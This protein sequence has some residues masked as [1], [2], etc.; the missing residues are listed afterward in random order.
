MG[1]STRDPL[2]ILSEDTETSDPLGILSQP[3]KKKDGTT[4]SPS[5]TVS[6]SQQSQSQS[7]VQTPQVPPPV[8]KAD[9][10][11]KVIDLA[12]QQENRK[13]QGF[14]F[15]HPNSFGTV[16]IGDQT[17]LH[18]VDPNKQS[19]NPN[20]PKNTVDRVRSGDVD[21]IVSVI[22][23]EKKEIATTKAKAAP[24]SSEDFNIGGTPPVMP[25]EN[26]DQN[27]NAGAYYD[28]IQ[29]EL[30]NDGTKLIRKNIGQKINDDLKAGKQP[31]DDVVQRYGEKQ[32]KALADI[33]VQDQAPGADVGGY[34]SDKMK[35]EDATD[36]KSGLAAQ[37]KWSYTQQFKYKNE[38]SALTSSAQ[39]LSDKL[40]RLSENP[41]VKKYLDLGDDKDLKNDP[42]VK[43]F[44]D[45]MADYL[46]RYNS[47]KALP[48]R[49]PAIRHEMEKQAVI[50][51]FA[52]DYVKSGNNVGE[53]LKNLFMPQNLDT[54][55]EVQAVKQ[56]LEKQGI[57]MSE[58]KIRQYAKD[59]KIPSVLGSVSRGAVSVLAGVDQWLIR[60]IKDRGDAEVLNKVIDDKYIYKTPDA[61]Q[62]TKNFT[63]NNVLHTA[64]DGFGQFLGYVA[65][66]EAAAGIGG[67]AGKAIAGSGKLLG[68]V[69][70][71]SEAVWE[72]P[73]LGRVLNV[74][75]EFLAPSEVSAAASPMARVAAA[76]NRARTL[77]ATYATGH[78]SSWE[79]A[80]Q[81]AK[82]Y[83]DDP[84]KWNEYAGVSAFLNGISEL[85]L[86][87]VDVAKK[88][89]ATTGVKQL[90]R[91]GKLLVGKGD[92]TK[93]WLSELGKIVGQET[94]EEYVPLI[95]QTIAKQEIF[96]Y[97]TSNADFMKQLWDTTVQTIISSTPMGVFGS[98]G[99]SASNYTKGTLYEVAQ[100][101]EKYN[102]VIDQLQ[103]EGKLNQ[104]Q[105][106]DR[107][108][109][110]NTLSSIHKSM[111]QADMKGNELSESDKVD[112]FAAMYAH[113]FYGAVV[114]QFPK[115]E[116]V[117]KEKMLEQQAII[118]SIMKGT[119][120]PVDTHYEQAK[121]SEGKNAESKSE[122]TKSENTQGEETFDDVLGFN[123]TPFADEQSANISENVPNLDQST[124]VNGSEEVTQEKAEGTLQPSGND[125]SDVSSQQQVAGSAEGVTQDDSGQGIRRDG[126]VQS[127]PIN[128]GITENQNGQIQSVPENKTGEQPDQQPSESEGQG[129]AVEETLT[130]LQKNLQAARQ[131]ADRPLTMNERLAIVRKEMES[132]RSE[133]KTLARKADKLTK[134]L[135]ATQSDDPLLNRAI[136][137][138]NSEEVK[139]Y[140]AE[141]LRN[142]ANNDQEKFRKYLSEIAEQA[143]INNARYAAN[144]TY[145]KELVDLAVQMYQA[146]SLKTNVSERTEPAERINQ[147]S[148]AD[149]P[150]V[151]DKFEAWQNGKGQ[152]TR[153]EFI[154]ALRKGWVNMLD[155]IQY[156]HENNLLSKEQK[157]IIE[158][159]MANPNAK[160]L[161]DVKI[162]LHKNMAGR[163]IG[164]VPLFKQGKTMTGKNVYSI[165]D[166]MANESLLKSS[167]KALF[168]VIVHEFM[169]TITVKEL[170][171]N[172]EFRHQISELMNEARKH[173][174]PGKN[175]LVDYGLQNV[176]EFI[177]TF[178]QS[179]SFRTFLG[180]V[181]L[182]EK[183][184]FNRIIDFLAR[185][186]FGK[187]QQTAY[188]QLHRII[189]NYASTK[190][191][192][193]EL[194]VTSRDM[195]SLNA[196]SNS[197]YT[198]LHDAMKIAQE[199]QRNGETS[200]SEFMNDRDLLSLFNVSDASEFTKE[201]R[202][203]LNKIFYMDPVRL[204]KSMGNLSKAISD[205][206][207]V[208]E[209]LKKIREQN[210][211]DQVDT[212]GINKPTVRAVY[213]EMTGVWT[214]I[215]NGQKYN[216]GE[217]ENNYVE[218]L[219]NWEPSA[220][221]ES[222]RE[223]QK[224]DQKLDIDLPEEIY[225][226]KAIKLGMSAARMQAFVLYGYQRFGAEGFLNMVKH[227]MGMQNNF[228][229]ESLNYFMARVQELN[230]Y[231]R[232][233]M[234]QINKD[235]LLLGS[236]TSSALSARRV[237]N[238]SEGGMNEGQ[239][240]VFY[241]AFNEVGGDQVA[242]ALSESRQASASND[243][244]DVQEQYESG[245]SEQD[246]DMQINEIKKEEDRKRRS[247]KKVPLN[248]VIA[249]QKYMLE[250]MKNTHNINAEKAE[251]A[252]KGVVDAIKEKMKKVKC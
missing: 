85:I 27:K 75:S 116:P 76:G 149:S 199:Y 141:T 55:T 222:W 232:Q 173:H 159:L 114:S 78:A 179:P 102:Q 132:K 155:Y 64:G 218:Q 82:Q 203:E 215:E 131:A 61:L 17:K 81:E 130:P 90:L 216:P 147:I 146:G 93:A 188:N 213:N 9:A 143:L 156:A 24:K 53:N 32:R 18:I 184:L 139:G 183:S 48:S 210:K 86:P 238:E 171:E 192:K 225:T 115:L 58:E 112:L 236:K 43:E 71:V 40:D 181:K 127:N 89:M 189:T 35:L 212:E 80:Y 137:L 162:E 1:K 163:A 202:A 113:D 68:S 13:Q 8:Q 77:A 151:M 25:D 207:D 186:F 120:K 243:L 178:Y 221:G 66:T 12:I 39:A 3:V 23:E 100:L 60:Q 144:K 214:F 158:A 182:Q 30:L 229:L 174:V 140:T 106:D 177:S 36:G 133:N 96:N 209:N 217:E 124:T 230:L 154:H 2:N 134:G 167:D 5:G 79:N 187:Q 208:T 170:E 240:Q 52:E 105:V 41:I 239:T 11:Q 169:H 83:S 47:L 234:N 121:N 118:N 110:I 226:K 248:Q 95:G 57:E 67:L 157:D 88:V 91:D 74:G 249:Q 10:L 123:P 227:L 37:N 194:V 220:E 223:G 62:V 15:P 252:L 38:Y 19:A 241:N 51:A 191:S 122:N 160:Q 6:T 142:A 94:L 237:M 251:D 56:Y 135:R 235:M 200:V 117:Y 21:A 164:M 165:G 185:T 136:E 233:V 7:T 42:N 49:Y 98:H 205:G 206:G 54:D 125:N 204:Q 108:K 152:I 250:Q 109:M 14:S 168:D 176:H 119:Y 107:K 45:T 34:Y 245:L 161:L 211:K 20:A 28:K 70:G 103:D 244:E 193:D 196:G 190:E 150:A 175:S 101:P 92:L 69:P 128:N 148:E 104:E 197:H 72:V 65:G 219:R 145:G 166:I 153:D 33:G 50:D 59:A 172:A 87:D 247:Q 201:Q 16:D 198:Q 224:R 46:R 73:G 97:Q 129:P 126:A 138:A 44:R 228:N 246:A 84:K 29:N 99:V 195:H 63:L 26:I 242:D 4:D 180:D 22:N 111:P 31:F 231:N